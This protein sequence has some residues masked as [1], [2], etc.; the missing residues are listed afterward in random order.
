[1]PLAAPIIAGGAALGA[2]A[3][4]FAGAKSAAKSQQ[5]SSDQAIA[6]AREQEAERRREWDA[7]QK[8]AA[9]QWQVMQANLAPYRAARAAVLQ[10]YGI[11]TNVDAP[12]MPE[13]FGMPGGAAPMGPPPRS[14]GGGG[15]GLAALGASLP[16]AASAA[17]QFFKSSPYTQIPGPYSSNEVGAPGGPPGPPA[18]PI[19]LS[20]L[21]NWADWQQAIGGS[22]GG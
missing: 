5:Q 16:I 20:N 12:P 6:L 21:Y 11:N 13:G 4:G 18:P 22:A 19:D 9:Y 2:G 17:S 3:L 1:M 10:K 7:Q 14:G 8:A 15:A